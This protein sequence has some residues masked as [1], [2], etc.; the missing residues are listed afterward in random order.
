MQVVGRKVRLALEEQDW[1]QMSE[2][3]QRAQLRC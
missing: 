3:E 1:R 2:A